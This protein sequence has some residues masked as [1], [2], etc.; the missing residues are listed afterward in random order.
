[1][2]LV[3][4]KPLLI[5][6]FL[7]SLLVIAQ[8][9]FNAVY[10]KKTKANYTC[11]SPPEEYFETQQGFLSDVDRVPHICNASD[12]ARAF[13]PENMV[14]G[15]LATHWQSQAGEDLAFITIS[16]EQVP[17]ITTSTS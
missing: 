12:P 6:V 4:Y 7:A 2:D 9:G 5:S 17:G 14:D 13:P 15:S 8:S 3:E 10:L 11:G 1:M 16:F